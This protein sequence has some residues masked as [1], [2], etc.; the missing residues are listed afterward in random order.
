MTVPYGAWAA[1][2]TVS[3]EPVK[4]TKTAT[5]TAR[6]NGGSVSASLNIMR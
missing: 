2:F 1:T 4:K 5:V 3:T 6:Y